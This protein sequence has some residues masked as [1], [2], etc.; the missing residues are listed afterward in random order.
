MKFLKILAFACITTWVAT[1][2]GKRLP[3]VQNYI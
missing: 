2:I 3:F 1:A